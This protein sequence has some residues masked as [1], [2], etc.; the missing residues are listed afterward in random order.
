MLAVASD[1][2]AQ[3]LDNAIA[4]LN[5]AKPQS[6]WASASVVK[7]KRILENLSN[8]IQ[9]YPVLTEDRSLTEFLFMLMQRERIH[10]EGEPVD[11]L[12]ILSLNETQG[13]DFKHVKIGRAHV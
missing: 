8:D 1:D 5:N 7:L 11:G 9:Q 10:F 13:I 6:E 3:F 12:Q 2:A 4:L